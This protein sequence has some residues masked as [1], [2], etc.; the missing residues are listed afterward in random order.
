MFCQLG[1]HAHHVDRSCEEGAEHLIWNDLPPVFWILQ[2]MLP[3]VRPYLLHHL[4]YPQQVATLH[5][6][7]NNN[8][9][10]FQP[11]FGTY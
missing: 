6:F 11:M 2:I 9:K 7:K 10:V 5:H 8:L 4:P 3:D 1:V